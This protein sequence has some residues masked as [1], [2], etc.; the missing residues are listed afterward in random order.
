AAARVRLLPP[1]A[2]LE[3]LA[4]QLGLLTGGAR[5][6]PA[7]QR[8]L[9]TTIEWSYDLLA[10]EEQALFRRLAVFAGGFSLAAAETVVCGAGL[11]DLDILDGVAALVDQSLLRQRDD[12]DG[13][14]RFTLLETLRAFGLEQLEAAGEAERTR[15]AHVAW[16]LELAEMAA[17]HLTGPEQGAWLARLTSEHDNLR[18]ALTTLTTTSGV[19]GNGDETELRLVGALWRF[20]NI[21]GYLS[22]GRTALAQA[23]ARSAKRP[24]STRA[25]ALNGSGVMAYTQGD[26]DQARTLFEES[27]AIRRELNDTAGIAN[28][29]NNLAIVADEQG[30]YARAMD[31]H[32]ESLK[33][34]REMNDQYGI[35]MSLNN[36]GGVAHMQGDFRRAAALHEESL[37][38]RRAIGSK[39]GVASSLHNLAS[40]LHYMGDYSRAA[41]LQTESLELMRE[42]GDKRGV[43]IA[44]HNLGRAAQ[45]QGDTRRSI[46]CHRENLEIVRELGDKR[47]LIDS[48]ES[49]A[50]LAISSSCTEEAVRL[51][52]AA[53]ALR[54]ELGTPATSAERETNDHTLTAARDQ[55]GEPA[56]VK[57]LASGRALSVERGIAVA[58]IVLQEAERELQ[59]R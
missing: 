14:P 47:T 8:S 23:L 19:D 25:N 53:A 5:D 17:S 58:A 49:I 6:L 16:C 52:G 24:T 32:A 7:R 41:A 46:N 27:L 39:D 12:P 28:T 22:E 4:N 35:A 3:R 29:L 50:A 9:R 1:R 40:A 54:D 33:L 31:I 21:R 37:G 51:L 57:L 43:A 10:S 34:R 56:L 18:A 45:L 15:R 2:I 13:E 11:L 55:L 26:L 30:D 36:M 42:L 20:W 48:L 38:I 44:L 59:S